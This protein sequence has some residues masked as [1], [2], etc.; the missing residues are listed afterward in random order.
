V[1][2]SKPKYATKE[3]VVAALRT[4]PLGAVGN[5]F[6][7]PER[8]DCRVCAVGAILRSGGIVSENVYEL[9]RKLYS[10]AYTWTCESADE[11]DVDVATNEIQCALDNRAFLPA[12]STY[13]EMLMVLGDHTIEEVRDQCVGFVEREFPEK[14]RIA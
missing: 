2:S 12:L 10:K 7:H 9:G 4:E 11:T 8:P 1:T 6:E 5:F 14:V 13:Y 3:Q